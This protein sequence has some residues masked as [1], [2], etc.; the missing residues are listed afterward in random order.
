VGVLKK[1]AVL[2]SPKRGAERST[3]LMIGQRRGEV[4]YLKGG[5]RYLHNQR[6]KTTGGHCYSEGGMRDGTTT[7]KLKE[8]GRKK[9]IRLFVHCCEKR[10][11]GEPEGNLC[12]YPEEVVYIRLE[13]GT[14]EE[15]ASYKENRRKG[16]VA[17]PGAFSRR[18]RDRKK[19]ISG[20]R[21]TGGRE[22][23][24]GCASERTSS[25]RTPEVSKPEGHR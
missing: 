16:S 6:R 23:P 21:E 24:K 10:G 18:G 13:G 9:G 5:N 20:A 8:T 3:T 1:P 2:G 15:K 7:R 4:G 25:E 17:C 12:E 19:E 11:P 22:R 14:G